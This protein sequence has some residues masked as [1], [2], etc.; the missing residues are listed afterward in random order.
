MKNSYSNS[1]V[2][3][4]WV[5][6]ALVAFLL[7]TGT[8][9]LSNIPNTLDKIGNFKMHMILGLIA[10]VLTFVRLY[11]VKKSSVKPLE[12]GAFRQKMISFNHFMIYT[13][14]FI[15]C[16]SGVAL[17]MQSGLGKIVFFGQEL[18]L[19]EHFSDFLVGKIHG[20]S[21]KVLIF[22]IVMHVLGVVGY[23]VQKRTGI[24]RMWF[25]KNTLQ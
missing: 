4:H 16:V 11:F 9:V 14:I 21:T 19:Y 7:L 24:E 22:F 2:F 1:S 12:V 20:I 8:L 15:V 10:C 25:S 17:S 3:L 6:G 5:H 23:S 18:P 13:L